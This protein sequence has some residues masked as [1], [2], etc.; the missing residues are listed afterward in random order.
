V[1]VDFNYFSTT[2][3]D[4]LANGLTAVE[5]AVVL[6]DGSTFPDPALYGGKPYTIILAYGTSREEI[7]TVT[8][9]PT[10]T[11]LTVLR[12]QDSTPATTKNAG[13]I[14]VHGVSA[15]DFIAPAAAVAQIPTQVS[16]GVATAVKVST[17]AA[18]GT[19]AA[20]E[21]LWVQV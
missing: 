20:G 17:S 2:R 4:A 11:T 19:P 9:K 21:V 14:V 18:S 8:A 6:T 10:A 13:D 1:S 15:R 5:T 7:C 3:P 16:T 12:G